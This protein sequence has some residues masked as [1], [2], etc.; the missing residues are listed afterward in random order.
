MRHTE[1]SNSSPKGQWAQKLGLEIPNPHK[2]VAKTRDT[3]LPTRSQVVPMD[4]DDGTWKGPSPGD[5]PIPGA[6]DSPTIASAKADLMAKRAASMKQPGHIGVRWC[7]QREP[8]PE[9]P[10]P[11]PSP[12]RPRLRP[13]NPPLPKKHDRLLEGSR[14]LRPSQTW[15]R[16]AKDELQ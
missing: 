7:G 14:D 12:K 4:V 13:Q 16:G 9:T 2:E 11:A 15:D 6:E 10:E 3:K 8:L 5:L 1:G